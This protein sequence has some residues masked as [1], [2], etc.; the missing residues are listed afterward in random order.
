LFKVRAFALG[1]H[2]MGRKLSHG[3]SNGRNSAQDIV[4]ASENFVSGRTIIALLQ[5][6]AEM[7]KGDCARAMDVAHK[8]SL[9]VRAAEERAREAEAEAVRFRDRATRAK[10][11]LR[12]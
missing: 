10:A 7:A 5:K 11:W 12:F 4:V 1:S 9:Q 3:G 8:L 6:A 2:A